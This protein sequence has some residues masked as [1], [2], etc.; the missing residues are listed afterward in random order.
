[1]EF[2]EVKK[3]LLE[4]FYITVET[5]L[6]ILQG[7]RKMII[8]IW[9]KKAASNLHICY[10]CWKV[11]HPGIM[12]FLFCFVCICVHTRFCF[13]ILA[14]IRTQNVATTSLTMME[15]LQLC[16]LCEEFTMEALFYLNENETQTEIISTLH[17]ACSNFPSFKLEVFFLPGI[18][19]VFLYMCLF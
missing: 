8:F 2:P 4:T 3:K 9:Y 7:N 6:C 15:N 14:D 16:Q 18:F 1:M 11:D 17:Q 10:K 5:F 12:Q 19:L 13:T